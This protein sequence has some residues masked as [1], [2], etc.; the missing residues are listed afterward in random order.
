MV[1][2]SWVLQQTG[3]FTAKVVSSEEKLTWNDYEGP[4][5]DN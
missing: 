2:L 1:V 5:V 3:A 4:I